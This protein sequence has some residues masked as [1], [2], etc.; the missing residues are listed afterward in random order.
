MRKMFP[1]VVLALS[2]LAHAQDQS[3]QQQVSAD[4]PSQN[5]QQSQEMKLPQQV[6]DEITVRG[7]RTF[8]SIRSQIE[9]AEDNMYSLFNELNSDD[10]FDIICRERKRNSHIA[11]RE[12]EPVFLTRARRAN[13]VLAMR[14]MRDN[15][16]SAGG[17]SDAG[18]DFSAAN[19]SPMFQYGLDMIQSESELA[20]GEMTK[21]E[22]MQAEMLRIATENP[23]YLEALMRVGKLKQIL[24]EE[25][26]K[27]FGVP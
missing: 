7:E 16:D 24:N 23:E 13:S 26:M 20:D 2:Q 11:R 12:C 5:A 21:F 14:T 15:L 19:G 22:A 1:V 4:Q 18:G 10:D 17:F 9:R 27:K 25:R 8:F 6:L 3:A